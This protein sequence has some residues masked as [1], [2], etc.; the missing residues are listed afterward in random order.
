MQG[1][2]TIKGEDELKRKIQQAM[3]MIENDVPEII[4]VEG[5]N[6]FKDSFQNE[7][8]TDKNLEKWKSRK[9]KR[10]SRNDQKVLSDSG[11]LADSI[12]YRIEGN[13]VVFFTDKPYAQIHNEGG[14]ITVTD[15]MRRFF[16][17]KHYEASEAE[18]EDI[19]NQWLGMA[20]SETLKI[21]KRQFIGDSAQL[22]L[23]IDA[24]VIR[25]LDKIFKQ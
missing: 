25:E 7:G 9:T 6:H 12:E 14:T 22:F 15:Q 20:L 8:F 24:K 17:A 11:E 16:W 2:V 3:K 21:E 1:S 4:G 23:K 10:M 13:A 19:A 18:Q 5:I